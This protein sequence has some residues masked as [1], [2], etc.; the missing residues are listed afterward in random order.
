MSTGTNSAAFPYLAIVNVPHLHSFQ[1]RPKLR[2][3]AL[4][5]HLH[6]APIPP[7]TNEKSPL[8]QTRSQ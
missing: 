3:G 4:F 5:T 2:I 8:P 7:K 6:S 1:G